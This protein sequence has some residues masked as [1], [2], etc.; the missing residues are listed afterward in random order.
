LTAH[1]QGSRGVRDIRWGLRR[2]AFRSHRRDLCNVEYGLKTPTPIVLHP[3]PRQSSGLPS[4]IRVEYSLSITSH[5]VT[6]AT[7]WGRVSSPVEPDDGE[8]AQP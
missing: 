7:R 1:V 4:L 3:D 8:C 5:R 6:G 2:W